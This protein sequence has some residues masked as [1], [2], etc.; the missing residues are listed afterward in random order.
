[1]AGD[2]FYGV[3]FTLDCRLGASAVGDGTYYN[4]NKAGSLHFE[5]AQTNYWSAEQLSWG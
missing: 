5:Q 4:M 2:G 3:D 1:M